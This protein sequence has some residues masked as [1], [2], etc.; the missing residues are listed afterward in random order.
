MANDLVGGHERSE[1]L[2]YWQY[3][4]AV[5]GSI[6]ERLLIFLGDD[7]TIAHEQELLKKEKRGERIIRWCPT[8]KWD[9]LAYSCRC[10]LG[11]NSHPRHEH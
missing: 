8:P 2:S 4:L 10:D 5:I 3:Y 1:Q 11:G 7:E 6:A 9:I